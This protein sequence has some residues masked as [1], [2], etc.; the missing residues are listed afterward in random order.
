MIWD[1]DHVIPIN[2]WDLSDPAQVDMCFDWKNLD[3]PTNRNKKDRIISEQVA[4]H[5][6]KLEQYFRENELEMGEL[7]EY[8]DRYNQKLISL[9]ETP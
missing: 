2:L 6:Q 1:I 7:T 9:G 5:K 3:E 4:R 8:M